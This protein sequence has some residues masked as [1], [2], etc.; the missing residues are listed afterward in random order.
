MTKK[1]RFAARKAKRE[2]PKVDYEIEQET[3]AGW[4]TNADGT[5][6]C[7]GIFTV[8]LRSCFRENA[9][10]FAAQLRAEYPTLRVRVVKRTP[11]VV[12]E[13]GR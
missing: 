8:V 11:T 9:K 10:K 2:A 7:Y 5:S 1:E 3:G 13:A 6:C 4:G 12:W